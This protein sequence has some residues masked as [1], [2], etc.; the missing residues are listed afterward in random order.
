MDTKPFQAV[1]GENVRRLR[2]A[3]SATLDDVARAGR[4]RGLKW[5]ASRVQELER[6]ALSVSAALL[7]CI[8]D[9]L[10]VVINRQIALQE[11]F[12][13]D[14]HVQVTP[15]LLVSRAALRRAY[16]GSEVA[17]DEDDAPSI[18]VPAAVRLGD[19]MERWR[20]RGAEYFPD[21][22]PAPERLLELQAQV[23]S[24]E[25]HAAR[26]LKLPAAA[27]V[28]WALELWGRSLSAERDARAQ[29]G[30]NAQTRGRIT[31][32]LL[33]EMSRATR[34]NENSDG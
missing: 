32:A 27:V 7:V 11:L 19:V 14:G 25:E 30:A 31:R 18:S 20:N 23:G 4:E 26:R 21:P 17:F 9:A 22:A 6:G 15:L 16:S 33:D 24:A 1:V 29:D 12:D 5:S 3:A 8:A 34:S 13:G 28:A 2:L 10:G